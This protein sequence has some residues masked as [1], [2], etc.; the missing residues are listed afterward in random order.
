MENHYEE[1]EIFKADVIYYFDS[2]N[3]SNSIVEIDLFVLFSTF[4]SAYCV[5]SFSGGL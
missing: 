1:W 5:R 2:R 4:E 3:D